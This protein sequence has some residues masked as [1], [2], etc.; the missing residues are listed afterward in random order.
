MSTA[1]FEY[2]RRF[3]EKEEVI[4]SS[5]NSCF[6]PVGESGDEAE[7]EALEQQHSCIRTAKESEA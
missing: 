5:C 3:F 1:A 6:A 4:I 2:T 7:L